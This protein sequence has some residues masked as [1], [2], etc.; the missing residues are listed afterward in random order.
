MHIILNLT[1]MTHETYESPAICKFLCIHVQALIVIHIA[2][3]LLVIQY[4]SGKTVLD[5]TRRRM[6][7][8]T[9]YLLYI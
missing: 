2:V 9:L 8:I 6:I 1:N 7:E 4:A 5:A 3:T